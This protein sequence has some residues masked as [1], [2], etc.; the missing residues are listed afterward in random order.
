MTNLPRLHLTCTR[1][2]IVSVVAIHAVARVPTLI[3]PWLRSAEREEQRQVFRSNSLGISSTS[4]LENRFS[5]A[6]RRSHDEPTTQYALPF[7]L[8]RRS[9]GAELEGQQAHA[10][11]A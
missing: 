9:I 11:R 3:A 6:K 7:G 8:D 10:A 4:P 2:L 5:I 1:L